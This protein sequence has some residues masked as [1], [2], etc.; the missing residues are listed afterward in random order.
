MGIH[1]RPIM[2]PKLGLC[3]RF[4]FSYPSQNS[5]KTGSQVVITMLLLS[6]F[7]GCLDSVL[8]EDDDGIKNDEENCREITNYDQLETNS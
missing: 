3:K 4:K 6:F 5:V 1:L 7:A 8:D 2:I